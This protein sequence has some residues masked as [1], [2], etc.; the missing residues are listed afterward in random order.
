MLSELRKRWIPE[1]PAQMQEITSLAFVSEK[2]SVSPEIASVFPKTAHQPV[3]HITAGKTRSLKP[4]NIGVIFSGGQAPGGHNVVASL[5]DAAK[6]FHP[7]SRLFGFLGGPSGLLRDKWCE[8]TQEKIAPYRNQGGFDLLGSDRTKIAT[9]EQLQTALDVCQRLGLDGLVIIGGDDSHTNLA[10]LAEYFLQK[11]S[12]TS[13]VGVPKTIDCDLQSPHTAVSFGFDTACKV[14]SEMIGNLAR[15]DLSAKKYYHFI[16][17]MGRS[18]SHIT[19]E[20]ALATQP[21]LALIGEEIFEKKVGLSQIV[22]EIADLICERSAKGKDYGII[23]IPEG[24]IEFIPDFTLLIQ[25]LNPMINLSKSEVMRALSAESAKCFHLLPPEMQDQLIRERDPHGNIPLASIE[26]ER[27]LLM[28]VK[29]ELE[30]RKMGSRFNGLTHYF[31][32]EGRAALPSNF[33]AHYCTALGR[34]AAL[35]IAE[36]ATG[37][38]SFVEGL[39]KPVADWRGGGMPLTSLLNFEMRKGREQPVIKK[40]LVDLKSS[41]FKQ[42]EKERA[43]WRLEDQF[44]NPGPMQF[45]GPKELTDACPHILKY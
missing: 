32:Y 38:M 23:L 42:F 34:V 3:L 16:K 37:Y 24:V 22:T 10:Y 18:A 12:S 35:L 6:L 25:E 41:A 27:F 7:Q 8:L 44:L 19:L 39:S 15:D 14:Y 31:G 33:D 43:G 4:L 11:G 36:G 28:E 45:F 21:N 9:E 20:C 26:T 29:E 2:M 30:K 1:I 5:F 40:T 13:V 17:L